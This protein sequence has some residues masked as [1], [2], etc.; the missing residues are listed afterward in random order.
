MLRSLIY[1]GNKRRRQPA[2]L[3]PGALRTRPPA[4][5]PTASPASGPWPRRPPTADAP[6]CAASTRGLGPRGSPL[7]AI[8]RSGRG[9]ARPGLPPLTRPR[10]ARAL[11]AEHA[12]L[13]P[14]TPRTCGPDPRSARSSTHQPRAQLRPRGAGARGWEGASGAAPQAAGAP[15][16]GGVRP[17]PTCPG[18]SR[19][20]PRR[21]GGRMSDQPGPRLRPRP[22][23]EECGDGLHFNLGLSPPPGKYTPFP[24]P[25]GRGHHGGALELGSTRFRFPGPQGIPGCPGWLSQWTLTFMQVMG[26]GSPAGAW[27][28]P[29]TEQDP[30]LGGGLLCTRWVS[31]AL[32]GSVQTGLLCGHPMLALV[33]HPHRLWDFG[34]R[35]LCALRFNS[36]AC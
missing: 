5:G 4:S 8:P 7:S 14:H 32:P 35:L 23:Q 19:R 11:P 28:A 20:G 36:S 6:A 13:G 2:H 21:W 30:A 24:L 33:P 10:P 26:W 9:S 25:A 16:R 22:L 17:P 12:R 15:E 31:P 1:K 34:T 29:N 3:V 18:R 27:L